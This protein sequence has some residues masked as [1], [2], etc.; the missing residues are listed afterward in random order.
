[1][2]P[3]GA[4][5]DPYDLQRFVDAQEVDGTY[6][7]A[8]LELSAE[9]KQTHWMWFVFPQ[10]AGLGHSSMSQRFAIASRAEARSFCQHPVLGPR[11]IQ[12][13]RCL[14]G[15]DKRSAEEIL[16][17]VDALK[18]RSSMTLFQ[19]AAPELPEFGRVLERFFDGQPDQVTLER[20]DDVQG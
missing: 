10:V 16:G 7:R 19:A 8:V 1:M 14:L 3:A 4:V 2:A 20:L 15:I 9:R 6:D 18:L 5:N 13:A 11:L 12:V 17:A